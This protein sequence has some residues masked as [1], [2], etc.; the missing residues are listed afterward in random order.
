[1]VTG[2]VD[3]HLS[4]HYSALPRHISLPHLFC[5]FQKYKSTHLNG[6]RFLLIPR[7]FSSIPISSSLMNSFPSILLC[8]PSY[9]I[10]HPSAS[11]SS[12][13]GLSSITLSIQNLQDS[14]RLRLDN[15]NYQPRGFPDPGRSQASSV[16]IFQ[17]PKIPQF[18]NKKLSE[19]TNSTK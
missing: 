19:H 3:V 6:L 17:M 9:F 10:P 14:L 12:L 13:L 1:M 11:Y 4:I 2:T 8:R 5:T 16:T 15:S 7:I 18:D